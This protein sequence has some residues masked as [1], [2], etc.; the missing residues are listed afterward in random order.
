MR[1]GVERLRSGAAPREA[2]DIWTRTGTMEHVLIYGSYFHYTGEF[3]APECLDPPAER[4]LGISLVKLRPWF[5]LDAMIIINNERI[6]LGHV[7]NNYMAACLT[8]VL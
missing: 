3:E 1:C 2:V 4:N 5:Y 8:S 7:D 6:A